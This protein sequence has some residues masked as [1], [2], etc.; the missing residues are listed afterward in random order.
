MIGFVW[1]RLRKVYHVGCSPY[2]SPERAIYYL[3]VA[4][5]VQAVLYLAV[6]GDGQARALEQVGVAVQ[7]RKSGNPRQRRGQVRVSNTACLTKKR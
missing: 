3:H 2:R 5:P 6:S 4:A 7:T 1:R